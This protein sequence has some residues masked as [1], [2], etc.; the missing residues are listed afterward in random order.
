[1]ASLGDGRRGSIRQEPNGTWMFVLDTTPPG[2]KQRAQTR[3]RGFRT[4]RDTQ[5]AL[6]DA[7]AA[8]SA[9]TYV[10]PSRQRLGLFLSDSW[11]PAVEARLRRGTWESY[12]RM[13]RLRRVS[14]AALIA[15]SVLLAM[16]R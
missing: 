9:K 4:K 8:L 2:S 13:I 5:A 7:V 15:G 3:R 6:N 11:L 16:V 10:P 14:R 12:R 1:M